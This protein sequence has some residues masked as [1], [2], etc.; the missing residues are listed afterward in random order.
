MVKY[1]YNEKEMAALSQEMPCAKVKPVQ[2][3][4]RDEPGTAVG[5]HHEPRQPG[6][7]PDHIEDAEKA[8]EAF[9][10]LMG[11]QVEPPPPVSLRTTPSMPRLDV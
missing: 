11:D 5:D 2:G 6:H 9:T 4:G 7:R 10:I 1:A 8:D 3:P